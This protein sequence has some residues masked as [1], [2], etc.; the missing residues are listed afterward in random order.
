MNV[1][2]SFTQDAKITLILSI[3]LIRL[4]RLEGITERVLYGIYERLLIDEV[5]ASGVPGHVAIIMDGNR[6]YAAS[7]GIGRFYGHVKGSDATEKVLDWCWELGIKQVTFYAFSTEN[8]SRPQE[9]LAFLFDLIER[10]L[11]E[12]AKDKRTHERRIKV[13]FLGRIDL[14]PERLRISAE[15]AKSATQSYGSVFLN[16]ALAYGGRQELVSAARA[17]A[18]DVRDGRLSADAIDEN[19]IAANLY[20][21]NDIP[22]PA[23]DLIIRTGGDERTSNFLPWQANGNECAAYFCAPYWP[24]FRRI[25]LLRAIRTYQQREKE[26]R[27]NTADRLVKLIDAYGPVG[28]GGVRRLSNRLHGTPQE[29]P[30]RILDDI[31]IKNV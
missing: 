13:R 15:N 19:V 20:P 16:V 3:Y 4:M 7:H 12:I 14:L 21:T 26:K 11:D 9:E 1:I 25:D 23:V 22:V 24:E 2:I 27:R 17:I 10:K 31:P 28:D 8:F 29:E 30:V 6:R 18:R 5:K